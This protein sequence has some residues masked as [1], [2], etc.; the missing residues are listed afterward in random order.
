MNP[1]ALLSELPG[2]F[3]PMTDPTTGR[4]RQFSMGGFGVLD[5]TSRR[6]SVHRAEGGTATG[7]FVREISV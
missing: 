4:A 5:L 3:E 2:D 1:G 7:H 6:F